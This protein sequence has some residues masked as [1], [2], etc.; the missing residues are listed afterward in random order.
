[1]YLIVIMLVCTHAPL[2]RLFRDNACLLKYHVAYN[3]ALKS[4]DEHKLL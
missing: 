2:Y 1:M 4:L 3:L